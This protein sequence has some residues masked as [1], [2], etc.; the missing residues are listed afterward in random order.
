MT[1]AVNLVVPEQMDF[2]RVRQESAPLRKEREQYLTHLLNQGTGIQY[3]RAVAS[4]LIHINRLLNM[5]ELRAVNTLEVRE[6]TQ[7]WLRYVADHQSRGVRPSS[8]YTFQNAAENWLR[9]HNQ[10]VELEPRSGRFD[11]ELQG[12]IQLIATRQTS[13]DSL[14]NQRARISVFLA[15][16]GDRYNQISEISL[17][18]VD[19]FL[20]EKRLSGLKPR[21]LASYCSSLRTFFRY[22]AHQGWSQPTISRGIK[23]P[24]VCTFEG[25]PRGPSWKDVRRMLDAPIGET[26]AGLRTAAILSLCAIYAMRG[27][28]VRRLV[29]S[30][31]DWINETFVVRRAKRGPIQQFPLQYEVGQA[32]LRYLRYGRPMCYNSHLFLTLKPPYRP[33]HQCVLAALVRSR[34]KAL[35]IVSMCYGTHSL[36][37]ACATELL[38][39]G[40]SLVEIADFLGHRSIE[41]VSIYAK[42]DHRS[43]RQVATFSLAGVR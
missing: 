31:F 42:L 27:I 40:S 7:E 35:N 5:S 28:E 30:D 29:I 19:R 25:P 15:W 39:R 3:V 32:V 43:L 26:P 13:I 38:R 34:M 11:T 23:S 8:A 22:A 33:M 37:H 16:A 4:R 36:R 17:I 41:S 10:L 6:A 14:H 21:S 9:F 12:F 2:V 24:P 1:D 20:E 18:E